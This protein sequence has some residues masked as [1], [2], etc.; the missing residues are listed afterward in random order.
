MSYSLSH[1]IHLQQL[2]WHHVVEPTKFL[3]NIICIYNFFNDLHRCYYA[4]VAQCGLGKVCYR[5]SLYLKIFVSLL[6]ASL[7]KQPIWKSTLYE[8]CSS[9]ST[10]GIFQ[11]LTMHKISSCI[12]SPSTTVLCNIFFAYIL[13]HIEF[14]GNSELCHVYL[15]QFGRQFLPAH[16]SN[17][18]IYSVPLQTHVFQRQPPFGHP[19]HTGKEGKRTGGNWTEDVLVFILLLKS[20]FVAKLAPNNQFKKLSNLKVTADT[21]FGQVLRISSA[22][23]WTNLA[24][25]LV[26]LLASCL[27][28]VATLVRTLKPPV[29]PPL[30]D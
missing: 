2:F 6:S 8:Y 14:L 5:S 7:V 9:P 15:L 16:K 23:F 27:H 22:I 20:I 3:F 1:L 29:E 4:I 26:I 28:G 17:A 12:A 18:N 24:I 25:L 21:Y 13:Q 10:A 30:S 19:E 11:H